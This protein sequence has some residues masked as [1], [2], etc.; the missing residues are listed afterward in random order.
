MAEKRFDANYTF[1]FN[2]VPFQNLFSPNQLRIDTWNRIINQLSAQGN[3]LSQ[4]LVNLNNWLFGTTTISYSSED[5]TGFLQDLDKRIKENLNKI[6]TN[7]S[8]IN[9]INSTLQSHTV[10]IDDLEGYD[11]YNTVEITRIKSELVN[12]NTKVDE[13]SF[14]FVGTQTQ[15]D[16]ANAQGKIPN[17][18]LVVII[19]QE[20]EDEEEVIQSNFILS[21]G[22]ILITSDGNIFKAKEG[23]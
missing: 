23:N 3:N 21:D 14:I 2:S 12:L 4:Y 17:G 10:R 1:R 7:T 6:S 18:T 15:Y 22:T 11:S 16:T 9:T 20:Q 13:L 8:A 5:N 19:E